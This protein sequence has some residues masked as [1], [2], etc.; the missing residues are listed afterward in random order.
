MLKLEP[1]S[2]YIHKSYEFRL[3]IVEVDIIKN[4]EYEHESGCS[5]LDC[6][7]FLLLWFRDWGAM[8]NLSPTNMMFV[9]AKRSFEERAFPHHGEPS[10]DNKTCLG[11]VSLH[12]VI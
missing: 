11:H 6:L 7:G 12:K 8:A 10:L 5:F 4:Q 2:L 1:I 9:F 3:V